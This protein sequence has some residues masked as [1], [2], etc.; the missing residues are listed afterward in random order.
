VAV[1]RAASLPGR[2]RA[3][4]G[5]NPKCSPLTTIRQQFPGNGSSPGW[6]IPPTALGGRG[7]PVSI[8]LRH[9]DHALDVVRDRWQEFRALGAGTASIAE[10]AGD[11]VVGRQ[12]QISGLVRGVVYRML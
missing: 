1:P 3:W 6:I 8:R 7:D 4:A 2:C 11:T 5:E 9:A 10:V 12:D